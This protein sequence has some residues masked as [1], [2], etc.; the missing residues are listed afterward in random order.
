MT[1]KQNRNNMEYFTIE[2]MCYSQTASRRGIANVPNAE[3]RANL[4]K[5][6]IN[7]LDPLRRKYGHPIRVNSGFRSATLNRAVGGAQT[8]QHLKGEAADISAGSRIENKKLFQMLRDSNNFD[9]LI[10]ENDF[11]WVHVSFRAGK[12]RR[13][14]LQYK[15][16]VYRI[17]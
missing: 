3:Q 12:N 4:E 17:M 1:D 9:Q 8:S 7:V 10:D 5:L 16:K 14:V 2:E 6:V 15:N 13:Q 11:Q